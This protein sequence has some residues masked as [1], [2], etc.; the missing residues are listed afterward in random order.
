RPHP[1]GKRL[2]HRE[3]WLFCPHAQRLCTTKG[4]LT[5]MSDIETAL[6]PGLKI[7]CSREELA[8]KVAVVSRGVSTRTA[9]QILGGILIRAEG[10]DVQLA[11]TDMELS[12]RTPLDATV[13]G[14]G[15]AVVPGRL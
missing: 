15:A 5:N 2:A 13:E 4:L 8:Q 11:A 9:V 7:S 10:T 3:Q 14:S 12:L 6:G 1:H